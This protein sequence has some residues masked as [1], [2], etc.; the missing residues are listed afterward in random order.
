VSELR[1]WVPFDMINNDNSSKK[2]RNN[3]NK[4]NRIFTTKQY[5]KILP[6]PP[7]KAKATRVETG[8]Q[9]RKNRIH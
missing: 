7:V 8:R 3:N 5:N 2:Q 1:V 4:N 6:P 9:R